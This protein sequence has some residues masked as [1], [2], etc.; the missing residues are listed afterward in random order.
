MCIV[1]AAMRRLV[2]GVIRVLIYC[3]VSEDRRSGRSVAQQEAEGRLDCAD[4]EEQLGVP[5]EIVAVLVDNDVGASPHS[6]GVR[7][8]WPKVLQMIGAGEVDLLWTYE[9]SRG[10]R[11]LE[12]YLQLRKLCIDNRVLWRYGG[13]TYDMTNWRDKKETA[14]DAIDAEGESDQT[15]ERILRDV[16]AG[17]ALGRI[18]GRRLFGY[19]RTYDPDTRALIGQELEPDEAEVV[20]R[21]FRE[22][23]AGQGLRTIARGLNADGLRRPETRTRKKGE[24]ESRVVRA[25]WKD[26]QVRRVLVN[27][28]YIGRRHHR[29]KVIEAGGWPAIIDVD[30]FDRVQARLTDRAPVHYDRTARMLTGVAR[31]GICTGRMGCI[32]DRL[33]RKVYACKEA[34]CVSRDAQRLDDYVSAW[35]LRRLADPDIGRAFEGSPDPE[36]E[37]ARARKAELMAELDDAKRLR[38]GEVPGKKLSVTAFAEIEMDLLPQI[39]EAERAIRRAAVPMA[40]DVPEEPDRL[41]AWWFD[42]LT[43]ELRREVVRALIA[44]VVVHPVGKGR[45]NFAMGDYTTIERRR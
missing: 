43:P 20:R 4:L 2:H 12:V 5:V 25:P 45:R 42:E 35:V 41:E 10:Q 37:A 24:A 31:C 40:V 28:S 8:D 21:I 6:K 30:T 38:R 32:H 3:R 14:R 15:R 44:A 18:H 22:F 11:D 29:G 17:A 23:L 16:R 33:K 1:L 34:Y 27:P 7:K 9:H 13:R 19:R 36:V 39:A 26:S